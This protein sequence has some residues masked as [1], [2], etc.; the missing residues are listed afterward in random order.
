[1]TRTQ[2]DSGDDPPLVSDDIVTVKTGSVFFVDGEVN[3][4]GQKV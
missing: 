4:P 2:L 1:V 3:S